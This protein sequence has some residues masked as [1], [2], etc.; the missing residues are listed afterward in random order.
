MFYSHLKM[1]HQQKKK[2]EIIVDIEHLVIILGLGSYYLD[3]FNRFRT[4]I[5]E[6]VIDDFNNGYCDLGIDKY[7]TIR[8]GRKIKKIKFYIKKIKKR[9]KKLTNGL[10]IHS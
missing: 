3:D 7:E 8:E 2:N 5:L 4:K 6:K 10:T 9:R 1:I